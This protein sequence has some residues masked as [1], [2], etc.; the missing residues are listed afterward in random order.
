MK[1][2]LISKINGIE[3]YAVTTDSRIFVPVK[4]ICQAIGIDSEGQ[5]QRIA[6]HY[7]LGPVAFTI[8]ATGA[9]GKNYEMLSLPLEFVYG[10][11]FT[12]DA[13][14]VSEDAR[15]RVAQYQRECYDALYDHFSGSMLRTIETNQ[16]E[17]SLLQEINE[18]ISIE[19]EGKARRKKAEE[20]LQKLRAE[21]LNPQPRLL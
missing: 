10:W 17:I 1:Q 9:D 20:S 7:I 4:P 15:E 21:R 14:Q 6:R 13:N 8:K 11:L 3:I 18:A 16:A 12:I 5:R 19:R 2:N